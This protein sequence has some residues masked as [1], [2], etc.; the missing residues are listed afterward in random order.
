MDYTPAY[1]N[2]QLAHFNNES[3]TKEF[4]DDALSR[5]ASHLDIVLDPE[6]YTDEEKQQVLNLAEKILN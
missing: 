4:R 2:R 5:L 6:N 3:M 1:V